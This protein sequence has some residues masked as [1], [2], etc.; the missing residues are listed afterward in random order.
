MKEA[1]TPP[2][3]R[4][5]EIAK[6]AFCI[7]WI[8]GIIFNF[9]IDDASLTIKLLLGIPHVIALVTSGLLWFIAARRRGKP[10]EADSAKK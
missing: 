1:M 5:G 4:W 3:P 10:V 9:T 2:L 7:L 6:A 8:V